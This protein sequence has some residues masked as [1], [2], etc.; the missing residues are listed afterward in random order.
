LRVFISKI[1]PAYNRKI[2]DPYIE[3]HILT[4]HVYSIT[5]RHIGEQ[6]KDYLYESIHTVRVPGL[7]TKR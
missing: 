3:K 6:A 4:D 5:S 2:V 7:L 1:S